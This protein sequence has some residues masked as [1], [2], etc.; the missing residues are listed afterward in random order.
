[1]L[2]PF[3]LCVWGA[4]LVATWVCTSAKR[5]EASSMTAAQA[6]VARRVITATFVDSG[7]RCLPAARVL[8]NQ[9][10]ATDQELQV[11]HRQD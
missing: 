9:S 2:P 4:A 6:C 5:A 3:T 8:V 1:M 7:A 11:L 10:K